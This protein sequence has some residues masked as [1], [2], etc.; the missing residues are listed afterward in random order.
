MSIVEKALTAISK[1]DLETLDDIWTDM[2]LDEQLPLSV[3]FDIADRLKKKKQTDHAL[4][5]LDMLAAHYESSNQHRKAIAVYRQTAYF[6]KESSGI[7]KKLS[8]L[9]K[10]LYKNSDH[11]DDYINA[12][13]LLTADSLFKAITKLDEYLDYD[14]GQYFYF[15]RYGLGTVVEAKPEKQE[16]IVDFEKKKHH[17]LTLDIARGLLMKI[18]P[19][20]FL[21]KKAQ[22]IDKLKQLAAEQSTDLVLLL[23]RSMKDPMTPAQIKRHLSGIVEEKNIAG[24]WERVRKILEKHAH[25]RV[26]GKPQK[27]YT[28]IEPGTDRSEHARKTFSEAPPREQYTLAEEYSRTMPDVFSA[29]GPLLVKLGNS[30]VRKDPGLALDILLLCKRHSPDLAFDYTLETILEDSDTSVVQTM[31]TPAHQKLVLG[32]IVHQ[33]PK[34][35]HTVLKKLLFGSIDHKLLDQIGTHLVEKPEVLH[36]CYRTIF[37]FPKQYPHQYRWMLKKMQDGEL[38]E[39][40]QPAYLPR[41]IDSL[42]QVKGI[43]GTLNKTLTLERFDGIMARANSDD[44]DRIL[45]TINNSTALEEYRKRDFQRIIEHHH[46]SLLKKVQTEVFST[47]A[48]L[49]KKKQELAHLLEVEIPQNKKEISRARE[50]GDLSENFE[51]KAAKEKQSQLLEKVRVLQSDLQQVTLIDPAHIDTSRITVGTRVSLVRVSDG[52]VLD[53]TILGRWDTDL[54]KNIISNEAPVAQVLLTKVCGDR[55]TIHDEEYEITHIT[56][57]L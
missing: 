24:F 7:R 28:A 22:N 50:F 34:E 52:K 54:D 25:I 3:F 30:M 49:L 26:T 31:R 4:L 1:N 16:I 38:S 8:S 53:Y 39:Y 27:T 17:F 47:E 29:L 11:I 48:A 55:V 36:D 41:M 33:N 56:S 57:A 6:R 19:E 45:K 5:L 37:S 2:V 51:Y 42:D 12:S 40:L 44:A 46:P 13:G 21:Y 10:K 9:Y 20:H 43:K 18:G 15:E 35:W 23:L 32:Y 14:V